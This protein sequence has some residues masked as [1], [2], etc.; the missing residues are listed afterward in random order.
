MCINGIVIGVQADHDSGGDEWKMIELVFIVL[1]IF[2]I[3]MK[4]VG[5]G[6]YFWVDAWNVADISIVAISVVGMIVGASGGLTVLRMIRIFRV[7]RYSM[8]GKRSM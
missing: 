2:E 5:F 1:F 6:I 7:T 8:I 4:L 3:L